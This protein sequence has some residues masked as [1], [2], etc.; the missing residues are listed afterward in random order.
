MNKLDDTTI[1]REIV[2]DAPAEVVWATITEPDQISAWFADR[3]E[4]DLRPGG[5][6]RFIFRDTKGEDAATVPLVVET[7][8]RPSRFA[9]RWARPG[10]PSAEGSDTVLV[11]FTLVAEAPE[12]TRLR[13][14]ET[15]LDAIGW[16]EDETARY[17]E[18]HRHGWEHHFDRLAAWLAPR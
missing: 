16:S 18:D 2:I 12:R 14:T 8:D 3:V 17:V 1:E 10:D 9:F 13:V 4:L 6:G 11:V 15:G 7:V 5:H